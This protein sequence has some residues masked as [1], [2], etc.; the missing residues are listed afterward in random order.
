[1]CF[2]IIEG[3]TIEHLVWLQLDDIV[4][5]KTITSLS[6]SE[7]TNS[8]ERP[9]QSTAQFNYS[10]LAFNL[11]FKLCRDYHVCRADFGRVGGLAKYLTRIEDIQKEENINQNKKLNHEYEH[12]IEMICFSCKESVNRLRLKEQSH[13]SSLVKLQQKVKAEHSKNISES[14]QLSTLCSDSTLHNKLL[15]AICCFAHDQDSMNILLGNVLVDCYMNFLNDSIKVEKKSDPVHLQASLT[16]K[17]KNIFI[18]CLNWRPT[19]RN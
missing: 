16:N 12:L 14:R 4:D 6:E 17:N 1:M 13:L 5:K 19:A 2:K 9:P 3:N 18:N 15:V 7:Q 8:S 10:Q 11:L